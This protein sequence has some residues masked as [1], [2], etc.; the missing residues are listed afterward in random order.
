MADQSQPREEG[1][2]TPEQREQRERLEAELLQ[3]LEPDERQQQDVKG[4][5]KGKHLQEGV[6][7]T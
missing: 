7:I 1:E 3:D 6:I 2:E 4:G 5:A